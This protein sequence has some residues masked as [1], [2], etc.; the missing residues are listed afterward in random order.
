VLVVRSTTT[1]T[2]RVGRCVL[3]SIGARED[4]DARARRDRRPH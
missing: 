1:T 2:T 3:A 4:D